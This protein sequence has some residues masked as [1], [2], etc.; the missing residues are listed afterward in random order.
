MAVRRSKA[1]VKEPSTNLTIDEPGD[2][3]ITLSSAATSQP[4]DSSGALSEMLAAAES[5][6]AAERAAHANTRAELRALQAHCRQQASAGLPTGGLGRRVHQ[7]QLSQLRITEKE[8]V[9]NGE[10]LQFAIA[11]FSARSASLGK[12]EATRVRPAAKTSMSPAHPPKDN[13]CCRCGWRTRR[14][15]A[16]SP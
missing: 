16:R 1:S 11:E 7:K 3:D 8:L 9:V 13:P 14:R 15:R 5:A 4:D 12:T 6:L 2:P 10:R